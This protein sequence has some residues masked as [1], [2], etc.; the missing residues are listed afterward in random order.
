LSGLRVPPA[1]VRFFDTI[2]RDYRVA[3]P[4][5]EHY[6][7]NCEHERTENFMETREAHVGKMEA[8]LQQWGAKLDELAA[9]AEAVG[10]DA[11][12]DYRKRIDDLR[13]KHQAAQARLHELKTAGSTR[14]EAFKASAES[15]RN[16]LEIAFKKL[17][18]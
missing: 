1:H 15:A 11:K 5:S 10:A 6:K 14:W 2:R 4:S 12:L 8:Q 13:A 16:E 9:K 7:P 17:T 18:G 3:D